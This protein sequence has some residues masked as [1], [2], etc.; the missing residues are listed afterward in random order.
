MYPSKSSLDNAAADNTGVPSTA[1]RKGR[2]PGAETS[3]ARL[4]TVT[5]TQTGMLHLQP[6]TLKNGEGLEEQIQH[7]GL[8]IP[9]HWEGTSFCERIS[10]L[11][12]Q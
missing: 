3:S 11:N 10:V 1:Q 7:A 8:V 5:F 6:T 2:R 9:G 4:L 12:Y